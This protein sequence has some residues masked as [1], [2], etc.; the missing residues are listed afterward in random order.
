MT[1]PT[2]ATHNPSRRGFLRGAGAM[3]GSTAML[4]SLN[5]AAQAQ[6][7]DPIVIVCPTPL[8]GI[9]AADGI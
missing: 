7:G 5:S 8:T 6:G 1:K 9:V 2:N 4:A 3:A